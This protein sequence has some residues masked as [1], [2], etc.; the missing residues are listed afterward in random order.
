MAAQHPHGGRARTRH[1]G[2][3]STRPLS[4][5]ASMLAR[6]LTQVATSADDPPS[7][8]QAENSAQRSTDSAVHCTLVCCRLNLAT[9]TTAP[10]LPHST[11][12][13]CHARSSVGPLP[14]AQFPPRPPGRPPP[15]R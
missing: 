13:Y 14:S 6:R 7:A 11:G 2:S 4:T 12:A 15:Q 10:H 1:G 5:A 9:A 3:T 8:T